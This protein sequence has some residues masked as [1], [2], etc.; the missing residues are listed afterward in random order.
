MD[1]EVKIRILRDDGREFNIDGTDWK[2]PSNGLDGFGSFENDIKTVDN[3]VGDGGIITSTRLSQKD[4]TITAKSVNPYLNSVLRYEADSFFNSKASY[5]VYIT[6]MGVTRWAEGTVYKYSLP[7]ANIHRTMNLTVTFLFAN[8]YLKSY[9]DFGEDIAS[10]TGMIAFPYLCCVS[11][12]MP[13]GIT[14]GVYNFARQVILSND[15]SVETYC[16][17]VFVARGDVTNPKLIIGTDFVR[18]IDIMRAGD[19]I[20][21]DFV[22]NPPTVKKNGA[23]I[24][25]KCD[26]KSSFDTM[27]LKKGD[28]EIQFDAD[29]GTNLLAVSIYFNK[30]YEV[31]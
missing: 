13:N 22:K 3:A 11:N 7:T 24:I 18:V 1:K 23:N 8:P 29:E 30:L 4:R 12:N 21:I 28:T 20:E 14:G 15:G 5:K 16:R 25:G 27:V 19:V 9:E 31:I 26:R 10:I 6:Y 2:I 17:A